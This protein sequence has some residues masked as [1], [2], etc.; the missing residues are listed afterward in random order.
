MAAYPKADFRRLLVF[1]FMLLLL[2]LCACTVENPEAATETATMKEDGSAPVTGKENPYENFEARKVS[3]ESG[4]EIPNA[5]EAG[6]SEGEDAASSAA[7]VAAQV[8]EKT[9]KLWI[10][11]SMDNDEYGIMEEN[12]CKAAYP[13]N[14][15]NRSISRV[16]YEYLQKNEPGKEHRLIENFNEWYSKTAE[17]LKTV[18]EDERKEYLNGLSME[19]IKPI[20]AEIEGKFANACKYAQYL[21][22]HARYMFHSFPTTEYRR[23]IDGVVYGFTE[24]GNRC[25][26]FFAY[27]V[28][29]KRTYANSTPIPLD[30]KLD[31]YY[32]RCVEGFQM[33]YNDGLYRLTINE[34][35]PVVGQVLYE[36]EQ[37]KLNYKSVCEIK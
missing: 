19:Y 37:D 34:I 17:K 11:C 7:Q 27:P 15:Y 16:L 9:P 6:T 18:K 31:L 29:K 25:L 8:A 12:A 20:T 22:T 33:E 30:G 4:E 28:D 5:P 3:L 1:I 13:T 36:L 2:P 21:F 23:E 32:N 24:Y 35:D 10:D 26:T 14:T